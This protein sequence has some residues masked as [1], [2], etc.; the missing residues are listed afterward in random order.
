MAEKIKLV[1]G[2][3][4][5]Q[6]KLTITENSNPI[7]ITGATVNLHFRAVGSTT[8]LFSRSALITDGSAGI[9]TV[10]WQSSDLDRDAGDYEGEVEVVFADTTRQTVFDLLKF[11]IREDFA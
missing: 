5:P 2:D 3:T 11:K 9:C 8:S 1:Q 10:V 7:D 4:K 6:V